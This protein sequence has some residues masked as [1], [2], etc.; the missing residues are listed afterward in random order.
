MTTFNGIKYIG[1]NIAYYNYENIIIKKEVQQ[2]RLKDKVCIITG[3][4]RGLGFAIAKKYVEEGGKVVICATNPKKLDEA[5]E[6]LKT[7][8]NDVL[9]FVVDISKKEE[10]ERMVSQIISKYGRVDVLVNNAGITMDA[11]LHKMTDEQFDKVIDINLKGTYL[12]TRAIVDIMREQN[13]GSIIN[14]SSLSGIYG[15]FGQTN[16]VATK[17]GVIGFVKT[18]TKE[19]GR[20]NIR[21][22]AIAP[23]L[24]ETEMSQ[25]M[26]EKAQEALISKVPMARM[27]QPEEVAN[28]A[29]FLASEESS[30]VTGITVEVGGGLTL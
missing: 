14:L 22:N 6:E 3:A 12:C 7:I 25:A 23:G 9:G 16:Y 4:S 2:V 21:V 30:Y 15:N 27:G 8:S 17:M 20:K 13:S 28:V 18:W 11:Q 24:I 19:L 1:I 10:I 5:V 29:L 26:P